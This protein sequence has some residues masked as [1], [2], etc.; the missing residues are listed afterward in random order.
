M[1]KGDT[2]DFA[3]IVMFIIKKAM[4]AWG[5]GMVIGAGF[6]FWISIANDKLHSHNAV[7]QVS[8][9]LCCAYW[10]FIIAE[11]V[12]HISGVLAVVASALVLAHAM[13]PRVVDKESMH[14][15]WHMLEYLGNT[16]I[17][18]LAGA[19]TGKVM[20]HIAWAD[21]LHL[22]VIY[23]V[24]TVIRGMMLL[25][26]RP[27]LKYLSEDK[28]DTSIPEIVVMTWGGLRGAVGLALAIQ[29]TV[30][31][32]EGQI[33]ER[34]ADRV[35][36]FVGGIA[37]LTLCINATTCPY[38]VN[39][40]GVTQLPETKRRLLFMLR[41][42]LL[43]LCNDE[44]HPESVKEGLN[45]V[46]TEMQ[47]Q[48]EVEKRRVMTKNNLV[49]PVAPEA[50]SPSVSRS[51]GASVMGASTSRHSGGRHLQTGDAE[52]PTSARGSFGSWISRVK[53]TGSKTTDFTERS[54]GR[55]SLSQVVSDRMSD[56]LL[57]FRLETRFKPL[58]RESVVQLMEELQEVR[59]VF[60]QLHP[61][62]FYSLN[63]MG[64]TD[65]SNMVYLKHEA[66]LQQVL[67]AETIEPSMMCAV[68]EAFL[69]NL[70]SLYM[71]FMDE[72]KLPPGSFEAD[73]LLN[74]TTA[75][76]SSSKD[77]LE[78]K[79]WKYVF[80]CVSLDQ[81]PEEKGDSALLTS[82]RLSTNSLS[83]KASRDFLTHARSLQTRSFEIEEF[84]SG[85]RQSLRSL[86]DN[87]IAWW[88]TVER[89]VEST[90][91]NVTIGVTILANCAF[92]FVEEEYRTASN[93]SN[94]IWFV[95]DVL[96]NV[97]FLIEFLLKLLTLG[98]RYFQSTWNLFD[99]MLVVLGLASLTL[100]QAMGDVQVGDTSGIFRIVRV[101]RVMRLIRLVRLVRLVQLLKDKFTDQEDVAIRYHLQKMTIL[102]NFLR[103][104][105]QTQANLLMYFGSSTQALSAEVARCI[106]QSQVAVY[107][108]FLLT[109][110]E[111]E[112][113]GDQTLQRVRQVRQLHLFG[114]ELEAFILEAHHTGIINA[115]EAQHVVHPLQE[116]M[117]KAQKHHFRLMRSESSV[118]KDTRDA[119]S[120][121]KSMSSPVGAPPM[122]N[123]A[124]KPLESSSSSAGQARSEQ[125]DQQPG[126]HGEE[127]STRVT[128]FV[129]PGGTT[130][131]LHSSPLNIVSTECNTTTDFYGLPSQVEDNDLP[132]CSMAK[133]GSHDEVEHRM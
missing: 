92:I 41:R 55:K 12:F 1:L 8:L 60:E 63:L 57:Q 126:P 11:G 129:P 53:S 104:R 91:F 114:K 54:T 27:I 7:I 38:I 43:E 19:L 79:D 131:D 82:N 50:R 20:V 116:H 61:D 5:L 67:H 78:L 127:E 44:S 77:G 84:K 112:S 15:V 65:T 49:A 23:V 103:A 123:S 74:S 14:A 35:L 97:I 101:F 73:V 10:S 47:E 71:Q 117:K 93:D 69:N 29:V 9:T 25:T 100:D 34:D 52:Q 18:F 121:R 6:L 21:Y 51:P 2:Y 102:E 118:V 113:L 111:E 124:M 39:A 36:F 64:I 22:M 68:N 81:T 109:V 40:L 90:A 28:A 88:K 17:F 128:D 48:I 107:K 75:V 119:P 26:S 106:V 85:A 24:T 62:D 72:G 96:F 94:A 130:S 89:L 33:S 58:T 83:G 86:R 125:D 31:R 122:L 56:M 13:W 133:P 87:T 3:D 108:A 32:A 80:A 66:E 59:S 16:L 98:R 46:L 4:C 99:F 37:A 42:H 132:V 45:E 120:T 110:Q 30:D 95:Q 70:R 76:H 115:T 105:L